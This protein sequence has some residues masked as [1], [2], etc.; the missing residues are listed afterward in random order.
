VHAL[1]IL[2]LQVR[3]L[4]TIMDNLERIEEIVARVE[5]LDDDGRFQP[6]RFVPEDDTVD[7]AIR[8]LA[9]QDSVG[10]RD[11]GRESLER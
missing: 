8:G 5:R 6:E 7:G 1:G 4:P 3:E 2:A 11:A 10:I 9:A